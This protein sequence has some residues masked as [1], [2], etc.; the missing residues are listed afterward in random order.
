[1]SGGGATLG[2]AA[3]AKLVELADAYRIPL[4]VAAKLLYAIAPVPLLF[5]LATLGGTVEWFC[6]PLRAQALEALERHLGQTKDKAELRLI[7]RRHFQFRRR[8]RFAVLWPQIRRFAG[9]H[10]LIDVEGSHHLD[11]ALAGGKGAILVTAHYG[12][13]HLIKPILRSHG[14]SALLVGPTP[15][16]RDAQD[17][18]LPFTR[19]GSFVRNRVLRLPRSSRDDERW[20]RAMGSDLEAETNLRPHLSALSRNETL[21]IV[22][23]GR[24]AGSLRRV[25][26]LGTDVYF[27]PGAVS[28]ARASCAPALPAFVVD[29]PQ[30]K[31][32][33]GLSLVIHPPLDLQ[34]T[35]DAKSDLDVN[36]QR[37]AAV[38]EEQV[39]T[40]PHNW[41]WTGRR[42]GGRPRSERW[43]SAG[44]GLDR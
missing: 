38:Y 16:R 29:D 7:A 37:F 20:R 25:P 11:A 33:I 31:E 9:A 30:W 19:T 36:L 24:R 6:S 39:R 26:V 2:D 17:P 42:E 18:P 10:S 14:R 32:P 28:M 8:A 27:A 40:H 35:G 34:V 1:V 41:R 21:I 12:H 15:Q 3:P 4:W 23:D 5:R 22:A 13:G 43:A 44:R